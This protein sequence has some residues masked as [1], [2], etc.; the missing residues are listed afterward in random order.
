MYTTGS[1]ILLFFTYCFVLPLSSLAK[2]AFINES[3][4]FEMI[5]EHPWVIST[6][7]TVPRFSKLIQRYLKRSNSPYNTLEDHESAEA[8]TRE[9]LI[10]LG[11]KILNESKIEIYGEPSDE[12]RNVVQTFEEYLTFV[13][14]LNERYLEDIDLAKYLAL[15]SN[16]K[17]KFLH[18]SSFQK[19]ELFLGLGG[20]FPSFFIGSIEL[21]YQLFSAIEVVVSGSETGRV[22][23]AKDS[24]LHYL[25]SR[26]EF[27]TRILNPQ[28]DGSIGREYILSAER[29]FFQRA[30]REI[31]FRDHETVHL[32]YFDSDPIL[33]RLEFAELLYV[34]Y[35]NSNKPQKWYIGEAGF[36]DFQKRI[37]PLPTS[38]D[39]SA[40]QILRGLNLVL[41]GASAEE[42]IKFV[43]FQ[44]DR[45][46]L[47]SLWN[48]SVLK[49]HG[50]SILGSSVFHQYVSSKIQTHNE[51][52]QFLS[53]F[54]SGV[55]ST[56]GEI[57]ESTVF[58]A[59][60]KIRNACLE[61]LS[62]V[63]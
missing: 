36:R 27:L 49:K 3:H 37:L 15:E 13:E 54:V 30:Y 10:V 25:K 20:S 61:S 51:L 23:L 59:A 32:E 50:E 28:R 52:N 60:Q 18:N 45:L 55:L 38:K 56:Q 11:H 16:R 6:D 46:S 2:E 48:R 12:A 8:W 1:K 26:H 22:K 43:F 21:S 14:S 34:A 53:W 47:S 19:L 41:D 35:Q 42:T 39:L 24:Y 29:N 7:P 31:F 40:D 63:Q 4:L 57:E 58:T 17:P 5:A 62:G 9:Q 33:R 44:D